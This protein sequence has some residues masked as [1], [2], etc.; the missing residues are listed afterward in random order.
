[1][2]NNFVTYDI[3]LKFKELRFNEE[4]LACYSGKTLMFEY[5]Q[6]Q[7]LEELKTLSDITLAPTWD[8]AYDFLREKYYIR[9]FVDGYA[10]CKEY[11]FE[12]FYSIKH[13][14]GY[15]GVP[16][17]SNMCKSH[18]DAKRKSILKAFEYIKK[19]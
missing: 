2:E 5:C 16:Y 13:G 14:N 4:C 11:E 3:A 9:I 10:T 15:D 17:I 7:D 8:Q 1:M 19:L 18:Y 12:Y 6:K